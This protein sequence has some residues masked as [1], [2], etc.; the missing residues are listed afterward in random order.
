MA[1]RSVRY[2]PG[3]WVTMLALSPRGRWVI[4]RGWQEVQRQRARRRP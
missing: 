3:G 4:K 2:L 1:R